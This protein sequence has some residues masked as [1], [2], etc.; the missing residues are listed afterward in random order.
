MKLGLPEHPC[1]KEALEPHMSASTLA[2]H[3][4]KHHNSYLVKGNEFLADA[5]I[6]ADISEELVKKR[7]R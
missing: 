3:H 4:G 5:N 2:F 1:P 6:S 7:L